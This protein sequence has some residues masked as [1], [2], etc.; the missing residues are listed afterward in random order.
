MKTI[1]T[2]ALVATMFVGLGACGDDKSTSIPRLNDGGDIT[3]PGGDA[4]DPSDLNLPGNMTEE[5]QAIALR[6]AT[7]YS[8]AFAPEG[9]MENMFGDISADLPDDLQDDLAVLTRAFSEYAKVVTENAN[10]PTN[11]DVQAALQALGTTEVAAASDNM[12]AY[13]DSTCPNN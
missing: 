4:I 13:F 8:Q 1:L 6:F 7:I 9:E 11:A 12:N 3:L 5:C 2:L 10:D